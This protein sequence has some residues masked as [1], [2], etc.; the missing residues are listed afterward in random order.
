MS[1]AFFDTRIGVLSDEV[2]VILDNIA[3]KLELSVVSLQLY[4]GHF[5]T[6]FT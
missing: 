4:I 1:T 6:E 5:R 2:L 3:I